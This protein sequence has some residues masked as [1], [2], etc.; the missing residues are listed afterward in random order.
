MMLQIA[1]NIFINALNTSINHMNNALNSKADI[2]GYVGC[3]LLD[4]VVSSKSFNKYPVFSSEGNLGP[5]I[6]NQADALI[7]MPSH[8]VLLYILGL[9]MKVL[10]YLDGMFHKSIM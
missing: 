5:S 4:G 8:S 2:Y 10:D 9:I 7:L 6:N 3:Y 1:N